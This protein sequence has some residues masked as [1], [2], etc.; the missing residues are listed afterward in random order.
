MD[1]LVNKF[2]DIKD[3]FLSSVTPKIFWWLAKGI[4]ELVT[5]TVAR[6]E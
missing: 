5:L 1:M 6:L 3:G 4:L 2:I